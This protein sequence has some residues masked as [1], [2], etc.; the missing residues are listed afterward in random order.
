MN[1]VPDHK[2]PRGRRYRTASEIGTYLYC[3]RAW[4]FER[5]GAPS[6]REPERAR[7]TAYHE[8]HGGRVVTAQ[9]TG[10]VARVF[11]LLAVL[12]FLIAAWMLGR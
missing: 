1:S 6:L 9:R 12:L 11:L 8:Q 2:P 7:G 4:W 5:Q 10:S 3:K